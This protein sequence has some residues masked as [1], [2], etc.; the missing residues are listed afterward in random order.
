MVPLLSRSPGFRRFD[1]NRRIRWKNGT[2]KLFERRFLRF[3][4]ILQ[5]F[6]LRSVGFL[7]RGFGSNLLTRLLCVRF[8][9]LLNIGVIALEVI[10]MTE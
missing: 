6:R 3:G 7:K 2:E 9:E 10:E 8:H 5:V 1:E 4:H